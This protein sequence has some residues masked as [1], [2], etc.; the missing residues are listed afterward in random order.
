MKHITERFHLEKCT[1]D[2]KDIRR[3]V[4]CGSGCRSKTMGAMLQ[5]FLIAAVFVSM[6]IIEKEHIDN[7][8]I[9]VHV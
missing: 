1:A 5:L 9:L 3:L 2:G 7:N 4:L 8:S 6:Q